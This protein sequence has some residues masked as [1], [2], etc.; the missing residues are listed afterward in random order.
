MGLLGND[1]RILGDERFSE[2]AGMSVTRAW[3]WSPAPIVIREMTYGK[4]YSETKT[5]PEDLHVTSYSQGVDDAIVAALQIPALLDGADLAASRIDPKCA[6][7]G[8]FLIRPLPIGRGRI[9]PVA[10][11]RLRLR[12]HISPSGARRFH[13]QLVASVVEIDDL[14]GQ[15]EAIIAAAEKKVAERVSMDKP[16]SERIGFAA[17]LL[18]DALRRPERRPALTRAQFE[19]LSPL[20]AVLFAPVPTQ[21]D[22]TVTFGAADFE[23]EQTFLAA[24]GAALAQRPERERIERLV[25]AVGLDL[26]LRGR[27]IKYLPSL[28]TSANRLAP[29]ALQALADSME[30]RGTRLDIRPRMAAPATRAAAMAGAWPQRARAAAPARRLPTPLPVETPAIRPYPQSV[31]YATARAAAAALRDAYARY[32]ARPQDPTAAREIYEIARSPAG[33]DPGFERHLSETQRQA[34]RSVRIYLAQPAPETPMGRLWDGAMFHHDRFGK[35]DDGDDVAQAWFSALQEKLFTRAGFSDEERRGLGLRDFD[36][37][38]LTGRMSER[39]I[40]LSA[41]PVQDAEPPAPKRSSA[42]YAP[43]GSR[44]AGLNGAY[45]VEA[46]ALV[47]DGNSRR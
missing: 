30:R 22:A 6:A 36:L 33:E 9:D 24:L 47:R 18:P 29:S 15:P 13:P 23:N 45:D 20:L 44:D 46:D 41:M 12:E 21:A 37:R 40:R 34:W 39:L 4:L 42:Y 31:P 11:V 26:P 32:S 1:G 19:A 5:P 38:R 10:L 27:V 14:A 7:G 25:V 28:Q 35:E 43:Q 2:G 17:P 8:V 3:E 16:H